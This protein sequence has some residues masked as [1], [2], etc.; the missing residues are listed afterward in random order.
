MENETNRLEALLEK[1]TKLGKTSLELIKMKTVVKTA[2]VV[3]SVAPKIIV[4]I[5]FSVFMTFLNFGLAFW[6]GK[7][8]GNTFYGFFVVSAFYAVL[9]A[10]VYFFMQKW[11]KRVLN[12]FIIK[13]F[14][15]KES[16]E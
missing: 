5:L 13:L 7:L 9:A 3:S 12:E 6:L 10:I 4:I 11:L 16:D 2:D 15:Q 8:M 1:V 14:F